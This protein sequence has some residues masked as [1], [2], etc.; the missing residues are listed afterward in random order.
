M[1]QVCCSLGSTSSHCAVNILVTLQALS[2]AT[3]Q[4]QAQRMLII[5]N[6]F[7]LEVLHL[8]E[9]L[10]ISCLAIS[11]CLV[12][13]APATSFARRFSKTWPAL[14]HALSNSPEGVIKCLWR[15]PNHLAVKIMTL[16]VS[17][18]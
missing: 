8:A 12:P 10:G 14:Y 18:A 4:Q 3:E 15:T 13:Y 9:A 2:D 11:P 5:F 6:L 16:N 1:Q 17:P 7:A